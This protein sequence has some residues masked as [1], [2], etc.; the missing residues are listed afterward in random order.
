MDVV[1]CRYIKALLCQAEGQSHEAAALLAR[2]ETAFR[3][4]GLEAEVARCRYALAEVRQSQGQRAEAINLLDEAETLFR[5]H[6]FTAEASRCGEML[7]LAH[8]DIDGRLAVR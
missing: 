2:A 1:R 6:G 4:H 8:E 7:R 3:R 5:A